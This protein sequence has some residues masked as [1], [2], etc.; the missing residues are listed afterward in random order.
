[1]QENIPLI[2]TL[3]NPGIRARHW[4]K[5]SEIYGD[6]LTPDAGT[7]LRKVLKKNLDPYM[8]EF[9]AISGAASKV[10]LHASPEPL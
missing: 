8:T 2:S 3:C 5:M 4:V 6:D 7:T 9:E 10:G 1:V